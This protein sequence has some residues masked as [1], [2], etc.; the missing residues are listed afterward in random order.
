MIKREKGNRKYL[1][2]TT[3]IMVLCYMGSSI[4]SW[5]FSEDKSMALWGAPGWYMGLLSQLMF[6]WIYF[7][8]S[9]WHDGSVGSLWAL[10]A[11]AA[12]VMALGLLNRYEF[13]PLLVYAGLDDWGRLHLLS[14]IGNQNWY[15][16][17]LSVV[18]AVC[19]CWACVGKKAQRVAGLFGCL[20]FFWTILTQG[21]EGG[22]LI[23]LAEMAVLFFWSLDERKK[24]LR[25]LE[26]LLCLPLAAILGKYCIG[27]R[28]LSLPED[29]TLQ[30]FLFWKGW[31]VVLILLGAFYAPLCIR[32]MRGCRDR[33]KGAG[34]KKIAL[35][36]AAFLFGVGVLVFLACQIWE[37]VWHFL[38]ESS[39]L[40]I[41]SSWGN[42][43]GGLW[44]M[45]METFLQGSFWEQWVGV[46]PDCFA[47]VI[48]ARY[49][50]NE[51][52]HT[53]GKWETAL[54]ANAHNEWL[55]MLINQGILGMVSYVG[56]F[57]TI[58]GRLWR[59][60]SK[61]PFALLGLFAVAGYCAYGLVSFQQTI[62]TPIVFAI[63]GIS[64]ACAV[65]TD[66]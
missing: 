61:E 49:P 2:S 58:F 6:A 33:L 60:G 41:T 53:T 5:C 48:Y 56:I 23:V 24:V 44:S 62:S 25:L 17:Y 9:R 14:T 40:R 63:L 12:V 47:N 3:D 28:G 10:F 42:D 57:V 34:V 45:S 20:L 39:L 1:F 43:R 46:G 65:H 22:Y 37:D 59:R 55:N 66:I 64:E 16:G 51:V 13:D 36:I 31:G 50:V 18:S 26:V 30:G 29:G 35:W 7:I 38:G 52:L 11:G 21:S 8:V 19:V 54:Y 4:L 27:F 32:E 15:C